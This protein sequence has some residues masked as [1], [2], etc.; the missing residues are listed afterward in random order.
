MDDAQDGATESFLNADEIDEPA[1]ASDVPRTSMSKAHTITGQPPS[2]NAEPLLDS[3]DITDSRQQ[4]A[5]ELPQR[6]SLRRDASAPKV[7]P[8]PQRFTTSTSN[9]RDVAEMGAAADSLSLGQLKKIVEQMPSKYEPTPYAFEYQDYSTFPEELDELFTYASSERTSLLRARNTFVQEWF[10]FWNKRTQPDGAADNAHPEWGK[11]TASDQAEFLKER[12]ADIKGGDPTTRIWGLECVLHVALGVWNE[13]AGLPDRAYTSKME[14]ETF[15][16]H[17]N[18][19][20]R[21]EMSAELKK[22]YKRS[23]AQLSAICRNIDLIVEFVDAQEIFDAFRQAYLLASNA[24]VDLPS[25]AEGTGAAS[26]R[27]YSRQLWIC[28]ILL[29]LVVDLAVRYDGSGDLKNV[30]RKTVLSLEP[31]L[32]NFLTD[33]L[34]DMRWDDSETTPAMKIFLL[35]WKTLMATFGTLS[36]LEDIKA[37]LLEGNVPSAAGPKPPTISAS[38]LDYHMFRQ[39]ITSKYPAF[40]PP[41]PLFPFEPE[42]TSMVPPLQDPDR[43]TG[44]QGSGAG[45]VSISNTTSSIIHQPVHIA[46]PAPSP[47]PSPA[48]PGGKGIKKQNYQTNQMFPF[49]YPPLEGDSNCIG[50]KGSTE[51][52]DALV[53]RKWTGSDVPT[54]ILEAAN[55]FASRMKAT[56]PMKQLWKERVR[57]MKY[58][59]GYDVNE[60]SL[61]AEDDDDDDKGKQKREMDEEAQADYEQLDE[62]QRQRLQAVEDFYRASLPQLQS[63]VI[64]WMKVILQTVT[65]LITQP[66]APNGLQNGLNSH[67][68]QCPPLSE[69]APGQEINH[70]DDAIDPLLRDLNTMRSQ[71]I[72]SKAVTGTMILLLKWLKLSHVLKFEYLT[73]LILDSNYIQLL[74]KLFTHQEPER[75]VNYRCERRSMN[76]L[77]FCI[78]HSRGNEKGSEAGPSAFSD[79]ASDSSAPSSPAAA[80]PPIRSSRPLESV[81]SDPDI[82]SFPQP[83]EVDELGYLTSEVPLSPITTFAW[84]NFYTLINHVRILQKI[85]KGKP[86]RQLLMVQ[87][88]YA[89]V[90][91][92][93]LKVPQSAVRLYTLKA[94]KGQVPYSHRKWRQGNMRIITAIYLHCQPELRDEWLAGVDVDQEMVDALPQERALRSLTY[95]YNLKNHHDA[96][97]RG[98]AGARLEQQEQDFFVRELE[99]MDLV[100]RERGEM[101]DL[102]Q[103]DEE[104]AAREEQ[105]ANGMAQT[106]GFIM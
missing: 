95:W 17:E 65:A 66:N 14:Q 104:S 8:T 78:S 81:S 103:Q 67:E 73:Q 47:P 36:D 29:Y 27:I 43:R 1:I 48:G 85:A 99:K 70:G 2:D 96:M 38:P 101:L 52:Q 75:M 86:H 33:V 23:G 46:T 39:E 71:E 18:E 100:V 60:F 84:R 94:I 50:G 45:P 68:G 49:L 56:R 79:T 6:P 92:K 40:D 76:F 53:G 31:N 61:D 37:R 22:R 62:N 34:A 25:P 89:S 3:E 10:T 28:S 82:N 54:S 24:E 98:A 30:S 83:P 87:Y 4:T 26:P 106:D 77:R 74:L 42:N 69:E 44:A 9:T 80:P 7:G 5:A 102:D 35:Y 51:V 58:E 19:A 41:K 93:N 13:T 64:V 97:G 88:K 12:R 63:V 72:L 55:L 32:L 91:R 105:R 15:A 16:G 20:A 21:Q 59:R 11:A 57:F 90:L